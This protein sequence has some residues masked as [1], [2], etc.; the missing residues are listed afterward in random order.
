MVTRWA[1]LA[2]S[3]AGADGRPDAAP[4]G[5][6]VPLVLAAAVLLWP[7][8]PGRARLA[9]LIPA[10]GLTGRCGW[11]RLVGRSPATWW[12]RTRLTRPVPDPATSRG[13]ARLV[14]PV[15]DLATWWGGARLV[16]PLLRRGL[17]R[18]PGREEL[19]PEAGLMVGPLAAVRRPRMV[20]GVGRSGVLAAVGV[21]LALGLTVAGPAGALAAAIAL[22]TAVHRWRARR[23]AA[24]SLTATA[25]LAGAV[26]LLAAELRAGAHPAAAAERVAGDAGPAAAGVLHAVA[27]TARLCGDVAAALRREAVAAPAIAQP[28]RQLAAAWALAQRHGVPLAEVLHAVRGDLEHRVRASRRLRSSSAGPRATAAVLA[29]LPVLGLLLGQAIGAR[30]WHV[31]TATVPGQFLLLLG[32]VLTSAGLLWSSH[33]VNKAAAR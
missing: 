9:R 20:V 11:T 30:P 29:A 25:D 6:W 10:L 16:G 1:P 24:A 19:A 26:G 4:P 28:L 18:G 2:F 23:R 15:P 13:G 12:G 33:I 5:A 31:L 7:V 32:T 8:R 3:V 27:A 22:G 21:A 17:A 14:G